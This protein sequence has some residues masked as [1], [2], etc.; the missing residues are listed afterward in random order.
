[1]VNIAIAGGSSSVKWAKVD[2]NNTTQLADALNGVDTVLS[3]IVAH[4]DPGSVAQ[5]NL[6]DAA[7]RA[8]VRRFAPSEWTGSSFEHMPWYAGKSEIREYLKTLNKDKKTLEYTLFQPGLFVDYLTHPYKSTKHV[9]PME[10]PIDFGRCRM[11]MVEGSSNSLITLTATEDLVKVV[12]RA[13]EWP[14]VGGIRGKSFNVERLEAGDLKA[15]MVRS[16][17]LPKADHPSFTPEQAQA[18]AAS[19]TAGMVLGIGAGAL[20]VSD[21]WNQIFPDYEFTKAE[22]F[23]ARVWGGKP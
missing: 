5:K 13:A 15:G 6:I 16:S 19:M 22:D 21:E 18:F 14:L 23:L 7:V 17:W 20:S 3:F 11:L 12:V 2:Y 9:P 10:T 8:G 1:M 4:S